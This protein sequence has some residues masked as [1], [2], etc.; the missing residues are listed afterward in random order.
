MVK[1]K[2]IEINK[3]GWKKLAL[4]TD[5]RKGVVLGLNE[6]VLELPIENGCDGPGEEVMIHLPNGLERKYL[7][8]IHPLG[9][10]E[11]NAL[12]SFI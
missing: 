9:E 10:I 11:E 2:E 1:Y 6:K 8:Y 12:Y 4:E 3:Y 7:Q 5:K